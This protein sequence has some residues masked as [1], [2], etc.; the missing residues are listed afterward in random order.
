MLRRTLYQKTDCLKIDNLRRLIGTSAE[1]AF[2]MSGREG[3]NNG[4]G[5]RGSNGR[6]RGR[7]RGQNYT[8][9]TTATKKGMC[10]ALGANVFDYGQKAAAD[11][12]RTTWE[13]I[14]EYVGTTYAQD[15][16]N[17]LQ[18]KATVILDQ[19]QHTAFVLQ[20]NA[21]REDIIR[22]GLLNIQS[23]R[24]LREVLLQAAVV[25]AVDPAAP[26]ELAVL[27]NE[28]AFGDLEINEPVPIQL[29]DSEKTLDNNAWRTYRE[30][31]A[32][33]AKNRGQAY[34]LILGP[35]SQLLKDKMKQDT[36][37]GVISVSYNRLT[38]YRLIE[39]TILAQTE[40]QYPFATVYEQELSFYSFCQENMNNPQWYGRFNTK[41]DVGD[42]IGVPR[43]HKSLLEHVAQEQLVGTTVALL[44]V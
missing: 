42:A 39:K 26:M 37:R 19:P 43:R 8:G 13:K 31:N 6:G 23:A 7:G 34:S 18:N 41:A 33:L 10:D 22:A 29:T 25:A 4:R 36:H 5:G 28:I 30:R 21:A 1:N 16:C 15:I 35:C 2:V 40:D 27:Q 11:Q 14:T 20:Q 3:R 32:S 38:L 24:R 17:E 44:Q 12:M 9:M